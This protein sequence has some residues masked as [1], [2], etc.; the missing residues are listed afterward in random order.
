MKRMLA[1]LALISAHPALPPRK[2]VSAEF[3]AQRRRL[4]VCL[5]TIAELV[6]L[7][8]A[9]VRSQDLVL[10]Y[11]HAGAGRSAAD[12]PHDR[13]FGS[14]VGERYIR[15]L[16]S[17]GACLDR[18]RRGSGCGRRLRQQPREERT[19]GT[20]QRRGRPQREAKPAAG[21]ASTT[22][23][24]RSE[25]GHREK[26]QTTTSQEKFQPAWPGDPWVAENDV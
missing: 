7:C 4:D 19:S 23:T 16:C 11:E 12:H 6:A 21:T 2:V 18:R 26:G 10:G 9:V 14:G 13:V 5:D 17:I 8:E 3:H 20:A 25:S 15:R 24:T 22:H 1:S